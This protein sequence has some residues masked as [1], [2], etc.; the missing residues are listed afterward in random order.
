[1]TEVRK[2]GCMLCE[3][4]CGLDVTLE[5]GGVQ[6]VRGD[7]D[8]PFSQGYLCP[9][10]AAIGDIMADPDRVRTPLGRGPEGFAPLPWETALDQAAARIAD[11]QKRHG[12]DAVALY[13]GN[14]TVHSHGALLAAP[15]LSRALGTRQRYSATSVDQL[16]HMMAALE[17]FGH[18]LLLPVPDLDRCDLLLVLGANPAVSNGSL[19]TAPGMPRRLKALRAR[20]GR[21]VVL[22]PR[23]TETADLA[24]AHHFLRPGGDAALLLGMLHTLFAE[25]LVRPGRLGEFV[26]GLDDLRAAVAPFP[27]ARVAPRTG[28]DPAV[29][30]GLARDLAAASRAAVYGRLGACTQE[31]G[32]VTAWLLYA[33]NVVTGNLD[34][35]GGV[36]FSRPAADL[37]GFASLIGHRGHRAAWRSRVKGLPEFGGELP[38]A[39]LVDEIETPGTGQ[40]RA[41]ITVA[42]N[43]VLSTPEGSRL[44]RALAKLEVMVSVDLYRNETTRHAHYILP[45]SFGFERDHYDLAF[46]ALAVR[47]VARFTPALVA[48]PPGVREDFDVLLSLARRVRSH[49]GGRRSRSLDLTL[50]ALHAAGARRTVD[51]LLRAGPYG[52][53]RGLGGLSVASL[54]RR[55]SGVDLGPLEPC[56]PGRLGHADGRIQLAPR[57]YLDD[58]GRVEADLGIAPPGLVLIGRRQLR[59]NNS[60]MHN[61]ARLVRGPVACTLQMHP[62]DAAARGLTDGA[63]VTLRGGHGAVEAPLEVTA[64][65]CPG[66]VSLPHGWGHAEAAEGLR[67]A[68][69][70][71]GASVNDVVDG[72]RLDP[73][74]GVAALSGG[75][76][77]VEAAESSGG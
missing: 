24:D 12:R 49:G 69:T 7:R 39:T 57:C 72:G 75:T 11:V 3:A 2:A 9:K 31:F 70:R 14:P 18:Q 43:P 32:G 8:D 20:G 73:L 64:E 67:V 47:N 62:D 33:L 34:R 22:D 17:M 23:R 36:M 56:L 27:A 71:A 60:W 58:L 19:M 15:Y 44:G 25:G 66:V 42:G 50:G 30:Q 1:M 13:L 26:R 5:D 59:S 41:L 61:A 52:L 63:R 65:V 76:V 45:T 51:A 68:A 74:S 35:P 10:A 53:R 21:L 16:P 55:P 48:P 4:V 54:L 29:I 40:V 46:Y 37:V 38:A 77:T 28:L 6:G